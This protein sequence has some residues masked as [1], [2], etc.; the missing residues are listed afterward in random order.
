MASVPSPSQ[1]HDSDREERL[2]GVIA[3]YLEAVESGS[4]PDRSELLAREPDLAV[5]LAAFFANQDHLARLAGPLREFGNGPVAREEHAAAGEPDRL[6]EIV[7]F[8]FAAE[9]MTDLKSS[10][11][12]SEDLPAQPG[13]S[14]VQYFGDYEL[15]GVIAQGGMGVVYRARQVSLNRDPGAQDGPGRAARRR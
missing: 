5:E 14:H 7:R 3:A 2:N 9:T 4:T 6:P 8:P 11:S 1:G 15:Q 12:S 13:A 10:G